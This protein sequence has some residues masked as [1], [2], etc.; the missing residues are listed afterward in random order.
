MIVYT[1]HEP[2]RPAKSLE[3]RAD[4][5]VFIKEGFTWWGFLFGP[6]W[7]LFNALWFEFAAALLLAAALA[8]GLAG[9]GLKDQAASIAY[10]LLMLI[11]GFEGNGLLRWRLERKGYSY[12]ASVAGNSFE[13]CERRFFDAWLPS[14]ASQNAKA[15]PKPAPDISPSSWG[16]WPGPGAVGT[17]PSEIV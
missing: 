15:A 2:G 7:L 4:A 5:V 3:E 14:V 13:E 16:D 8:A 12:L 1:V 9:L 6:L 10:L 17:L 11:I